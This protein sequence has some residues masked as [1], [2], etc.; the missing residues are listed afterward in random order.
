M[1]SN[2]ISVNVK[3]SLCSSPL[4]S[5]AIVYTV[6][7][8][9]RKTKNDFLSISHGVNNKIVVLQLVSALNVNENRHTQFEQ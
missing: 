7:I 3:T 2:I 9:Y 8:A 1:T 4:M 6:R 5:R